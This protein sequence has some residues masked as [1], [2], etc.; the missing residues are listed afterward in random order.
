MSDFDRAAITELGLYIENEGKLQPQ[1]KSII[2]NLDR[3]V[4]AGK[5]DGKLA[6]KLWLYLVDNAAV[7]YQ[8]RGGT[9][10][11]A[12]RQ[13]PTA[14]RKVIAERLAREYEDEARERG[15]HIHDDRHLCTACAAHEVKDI[16]DQGERLMKYEEARTSRK[17]TGRRSPNF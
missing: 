17:K 4:K 9:A 2:T 5:Y 3:K 11:E 8:G 10:Q 14:V 16:T 6:P 15:L 13:F 12:R 1:F 7:M